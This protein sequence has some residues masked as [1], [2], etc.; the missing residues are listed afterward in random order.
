[1][2]KKEAATVAIKQLPGATQEDW[3]AAATNLCGDTVSVST[4]RAALAE[5]PD[6]VKRGR[7][8]P[9]GAK[10]GNDATPPKAIVRHG[11]VAVRPAIYTPED[12]KQDKAEES[13]EFVSKAAARIARKEYLMSFLQRSVADLQ[14]PASF[15]EVRE[16]LDELEEIAI[17]EE[18]G[19]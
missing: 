5:M 16:A 8:R 4:V 17:A 12:R 6:A 7:G 2:T 11:K 1:M 18:R 3:A 13:E 9:A 15:D 14:Y 19:N 10:T